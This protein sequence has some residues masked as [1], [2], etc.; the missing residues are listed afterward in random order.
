MSPGEGFDMWELRKSNERGL[1]DHG[2]LKSRHSF[3][4]ADYYDPKYMGFGVLRVINE[5]RVAPGK[6][7]GTHG[8]TDME[9]ISYVLG[10]QLAHRDSMGTGSVIVPGDVQRMSAGTGV[11][12]SEMNAS[13][14]DPVHFLQIWI[15]PAVLGIPPSYEQKHFP[16]AEMRGKLR[17]VVAADGSEGAV[18]LHQDVR[19]Y[20]GRF[21]AAEEATLSPAERRRGYVHVACGSIG[22]ND[23][24][25]E[26]GDALKIAGPQTLRFHSG[27]NAELLVFGQPG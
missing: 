7:F 14:K 18:T 12:H 13:T 9:I 25:L 24:R 8:H 4:F 16:P 2:W 10:G 26:A 6:G 15:Q 22:V 5:D 19:L 21:D 23:T 11:R 17:L 1:A 3:S 20:A 27:A